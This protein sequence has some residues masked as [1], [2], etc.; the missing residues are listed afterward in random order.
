M[1]TIKQTDTCNVMFWVFFYKDSP[2]ERLVWVRGHLRGGDPASRT[3]ARCLDREQASS[4]NSEWYIRR[5]GVE[6]DRRRRKLS[7][8][9]TQI[10][11]CAL[12]FFLLKEPEGGNST[13][14]LRACVSPIYC[15]AWFRQYISVLLVLYRN[16][17]KTPPASPSRAVC[18]FLLIWSELI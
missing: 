17:S 8:R 4:V 3:Y 2:D 10:K 5:S 15:H 12:F 7:R 11:E 16:I 9:T 1:T 13:S 6:T 14:G 18:P